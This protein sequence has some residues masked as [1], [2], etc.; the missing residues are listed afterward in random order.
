MLNET[1][2]EKLTERLVNRVEEVNSY[3]LKLIGEQINRIG[4]MTPTNANRLVNVLK[5]GGDIDKIAY[6]LSEITELNIKDIYKMFEEIAKTNYNFAKEFY[7]YRGLDYIPYED[8]TYL[9]NEVKALARTTANTY[10]NLSKTIGFTTTDSLGN[11]VF[12]DIAT[13]YNNTIDKAILSISQGK[14]SYID[15]MRDTIQELGYGGIKTVN[16]ESGYSRRLDS[17]VR[18]NI[19]DGIRD[20]HNEVQK[21]IGDAVGTDGIEISVHENPAIDHEDIQ[22]MQYTNAEFEKLNNE[23]DRPISTMNCYHYIF[24]IIKGI[25]KPRY[26]KEELK[27]IR[28]RND[29]GFEFEGNKYTMYE[30]QQLQRKIETEIRRN[31]DVHTIAKA[32]GD[33]ELVAK[34]QIKIRQLSKK[35]KELSDVSGLPTKIERLKVEGFKRVNLKKLGE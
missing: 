33:N 28:E 9:Q 32:S 15:T 14:N 13:T 10:F 21:Y 20:L 3:T 1:I 22:G 23:L 16:Y 24:S 30:G 35:Y 25:N 6:K 19:M 11:K 17:S 31:K 29:K 8:N 2:I 34:S 18:M 5:Y 4:S 12:D 27:A 26:S 7:D